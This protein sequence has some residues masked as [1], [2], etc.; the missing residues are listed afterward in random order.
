ME[1]VLA[2]VPNFLLIFCRIT[3]FFVVAPI[4]ST[5]NVPAHFKIGLSFFVAFMVFGS[6]GMGN[7]VSIDGD[8]IL[9]ILREVL[10]GLAIGFIGLMFMYVFQIAGAFIDMQIGLGIANIIDPMTGLHS[11]IVGSFKY[12]IAI[13]LFLSFNGHHYLLAAIMDSYEWVPLQN[14]FFGDLANGNVAHFMVRSFATM[15]ALAFQLAA[16][17]VVAMFLTDVGLGV[18]AR[19]APQFN[20]F[21]VGIPIKLVIGFLILLL[22]IPGFIHL[23]GKVFTVM[24]D[25]IWQLIRLLGQA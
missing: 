17:I 1:M 4:F 8:Y 19:V 14:G 15:F 25:T 5:Q 7:P 3:S 12:V 23:F 20:I 16:P 24:I 6:I 21:V 22:T 13:L 10:I 11:P 9:L 2:Y 18:L